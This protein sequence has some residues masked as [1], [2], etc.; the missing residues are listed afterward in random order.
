MIL[1]S[2]QEALA[3][4]LA[5]NHWRRNLRRWI[6]AARCAPGF[7]Q[8]TPAAWYRAHDLGCDIA[9]RKLWIHLSGQKK[10]DRNHRIDVASGN[11]SHGIDHCEQRQ[12]ERE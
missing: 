1:K 11:R 2:A 9:A 10:V 5:V 4:I 3:P 7:D 6:I 12:A 8:Q